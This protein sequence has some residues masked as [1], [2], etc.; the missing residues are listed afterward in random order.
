[1]SGRQSLGV[2]F[3]FWLAVLALLSALGHLTSCLGC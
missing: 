2:G 1:M 3:W